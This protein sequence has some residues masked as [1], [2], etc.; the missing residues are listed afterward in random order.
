MGLLIP[1][2]AA[3]APT[4]CCTSEA[5]RFAEGRAVRWML[6]LCAAVLVS[7]SAAALDASSAHAEEYDLIGGLF[8]HPS[9][10]STPSPPHQQRIAVEHAT[11]NILT[12]TFRTT[13]SMSTARR[14]T[15]PVSDELRCGRAERSVRHRHRSG[16]RCGVRQRSGQRADRA[17]HR[18]P[19]DAAGLHA[20]QQLTSPAPGNAAGEIG[21]FAAALAIDATADKLLVADPGN[22]MSQALHADRRVRQLRLRRCRRATCAC[23]RS[24]RSFHRPARPGG[25]LDR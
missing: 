23:R 4:S 10:P 20:R 9:D 6:A 8:A 11:G 18:R 1:G 22:N 16:N 2:A 24:R 17:L 14:P 7:L 21:N 15:G 5:R 3:A 13:G 12:P 19:R 25:G